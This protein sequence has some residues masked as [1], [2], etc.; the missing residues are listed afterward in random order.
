MSP[1]APGWDA[2]AVDWD[3]VGSI[4][5]MVQHGTEDP[6]IPVRADARSHR[7]FWPS[8]TSRSSPGS[9]RWVI[10]SRWRAC[11]DAHAWLD[12]VVAGEQPREALPE[13]L[14]EGPVEE[15]DRRDLRV[16]GA[17]Q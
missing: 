12:Q 5:V 8:T 11:R 17:A 2:L 9:T 4:P 15:R 3:A 6:M 13:P 16:R 10:R 14:P 7:V 1:F